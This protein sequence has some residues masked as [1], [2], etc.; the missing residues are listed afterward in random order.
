MR[1]NKQYLDILA[2]KFNFETEEQYVEFLESMT[3][4]S[5]RQENFYFI[6]SLQKISLQGPL[7]KTM[8]IQFFQFFKFQ[9]CY[10]NL[11]MLWGFGSFVSCGMKL[12]CIVLFGLNGWQ[13]IKPWSGG[14]KE[15]TH[16]GDLLFLPFFENGP[17][18]RERNLH[19][20]LMYSHHML[21][22]FIPRCDAAPQDLFTGGLAKSWRVT[23]TNFSLLRRFSFS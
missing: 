18:N 5:N 15:F 11:S 19:G 3:A 10:F 20:S 13:Q 1:W 8:F 12:F 7:C 17:Q 14:V 4:V 21:A 6:Q 9:F 16:T 2:S 23:L 22:V